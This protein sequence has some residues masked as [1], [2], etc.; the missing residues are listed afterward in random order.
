MLEGHFYT[1]TVE[2]WATDH[3]YLTSFRR[4]AR[5][6]V[7]LPVEGARVS[8]LET[9]EEIPSLLT[10]QCPE[11]KEK[12]EGSKVVEVMGKTRWE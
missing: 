7:F 5:C 11:C 9:A 4:W 6:R 3:T 8:V 1:I 2:V 12:W 10:T